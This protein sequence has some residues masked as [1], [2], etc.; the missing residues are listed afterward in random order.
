VS[1]HLFEREQVVGRAVGE[2]FDFFS[3]AANL[4]LLTPP[5][6]GFTMLTPEP[7]EMRAGT[8]LDYRLRVR[9]V[10][11]HWRS[12]IEQWEPEVRFV[13]RQMKGPYKLWLHT[14]EFE[15][16]PGGTKVKDSVRFELPFGRI[17]EL[18]GLALV[19][20]DLGR[21]FDYRRE[22]VARLLG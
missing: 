9:G 11:M 1:A 2:V 8:L 5:A 13:D 20:R 4:A 3:K 6:M 12:R 17:G 18:G 7:I 16:V 19:E 22:T 10:P 14:H 15:S 21:I